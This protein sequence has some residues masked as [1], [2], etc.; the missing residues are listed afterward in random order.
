LREPGWGGGSSLYRVV[1][2]RWVEL[3]MARAV[4]ILDR[5]PEATRITFRT[6]VN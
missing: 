1:V 6:P 3:E 5:S 2:E 4:G